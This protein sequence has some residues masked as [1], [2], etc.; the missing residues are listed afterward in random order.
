MKAQG[1]TPKDRILSEG[2]PMTT[3]E[4]LDKYSEQVEQISI[5]LLCA[6]ITPR[7]A[8]HRAFTLGVD[9][10]REFSAFIDKPAGDA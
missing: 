8:V 6:H 10:H 7:A 3:K 4:F 1:I 2:R 5:D 9:F